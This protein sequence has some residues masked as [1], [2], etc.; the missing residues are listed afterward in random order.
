MV[1][2]VSPR[3]LTDWIN[4]MPFVPVNHTMLVEIRMNIVGQKVENTIWVH[5]LDLIDADALALVGETVKAWWISDYAPQVS[6]LVSL[7]EIV[8]TDQTTATSGQVTIDGDH[9]LGGQIG[10]T[11]TTNSTFAVSFRTASRGRAFRGR[12]YI[13]GIP[14]EHMAETNVVEASWASDIVTAY[15]NLLTALGDAGFQWVIASRFSGVDPDT[16]KPIPR[17]AGVITDVI[18]VV[19]S[20]LTIDSQRRRLPGRGQ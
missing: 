5:A 9:Q 1:G 20:D 4:A 12:N 19:A 8:V 16:G 3:S 13:V 11:L 6:D 10:G 15:E 7:T 14:L 18:T 2:G 17:A